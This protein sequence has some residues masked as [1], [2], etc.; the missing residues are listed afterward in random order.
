MSFFELKRVLSSPNEQLLRYITNSPSALTQNQMS[1]SLHLCR[2]SNPQP[3]DDKPSS[4][5]SSS[6]A[7]LTQC[8]SFFSLSD[9]TSLPA[10]SILH[11]GQHQDHR[12]VAFTSL[13]SRGCCRCA[14]MAQL[15]PLLLSPLT[16][17]PCQDAIIRRQPQKE[18]PCIVTASTMTRECEQARFRFAQRSGLGVRRYEG[19]ALSSPRAGVTLMSVTNDD[20]SMMHV[21]RQHVNLKG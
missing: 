8:Q 1:G 11:I 21:G 19:K 7:P 5:A 18:E 13:A 14:M 17:S 9:Y 20:R 16:S 10:L 3:L 15:H 6:T 4:G 2:D 12:P